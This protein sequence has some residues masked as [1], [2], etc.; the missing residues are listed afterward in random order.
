MHRKTMAAL[1]LGLLMLVLSSCATRVTA[2]Y[3]AYDPAYSDYHTWSPAETTYY[4]QWII[5]THHRHRDYRRLRS[6]E[7]RQYWQWRH[8]HPDRH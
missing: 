1:A 4:N 7:Q 3:R 6:R 2:G 8:A 5:E